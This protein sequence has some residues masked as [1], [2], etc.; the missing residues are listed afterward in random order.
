[1]RE[2]VG[3]GLLHRGSRPLA[4]PDEEPGPVVVAEAGAEL[5][6]PPDRVLPEDHHPR[7][8]ADPEPAR[9]AEP[10][11]RASPPVMK[12]CQQ[13]AREASTLGE[14][15]IVSNDSPVRCQR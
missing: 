9:D 15:D 1:V 7:P 10:A 5:A 6:P 2:L 4:P 11:H 3:E 14:S 8:V 13:P 12:P